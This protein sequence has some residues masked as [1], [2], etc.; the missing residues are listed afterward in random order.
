[1]TT[2]RC[3]HTHTHTYENLFGQA[4]TLDDIITHL[5]YNCK[6]MQLKGYETFPSNILYFSIFGGCQLFVEGMQKSALVQ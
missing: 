2:Y 4:T 5:L 3:K 6:I 1:M